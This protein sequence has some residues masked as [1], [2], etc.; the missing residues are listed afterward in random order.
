MMYWRGI[1][2]QTLL[3]AGLVI[4]STQAV[5]AALPQPDLN[6]ISFWFK[7]LL[8]VSLG[9][10][11]WFIQK[12]D[13]RLEKLAEANLIGR[14][15]L[16]EHEYRQLKTEVSLLRETLPKEYYG[17]DEMRE[18]FRKVEDSLKAIHVRMDVIRDNLH[19]SSRSIADR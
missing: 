17:K 16:V 1:T 7:L 10:G 11:G 8:G 6:D 15:M 19:S 18:H 5:A 12:H 2:A 4:T 13:A 14:M 3:F 9:V